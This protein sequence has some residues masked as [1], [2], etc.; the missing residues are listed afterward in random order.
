MN[1]K[2]SASYFRT[3]K[4]KRISG[5]MRFQLILLNV[6]RA[7]IVLEGFPLMLK[8]FCNLKL[9]ATY[10]CFSNTMHRLP[11]VKDLS[12]AKILPHLKGNG[13][14]IKLKMKTGIVIC[15]SLWL[16]PMVTWRIQIHK[17]STGG[18]NAVSGS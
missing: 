14:R 16:R 9:T 13:V 7:L 8:S 15:T 1:K 6:I 2:L 10:G 18:E 12:G 17:K 4:V 11:A 5:N 3:R